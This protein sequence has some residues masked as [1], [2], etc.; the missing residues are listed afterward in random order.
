MG[1]EEGPKG[2]KFSPVSILIVRWWTQLCQ[3]RGTVF[4]QRRQ[5][6]LL[7][8]G[9]H[10]H[11]CDGEGVEKDTAGYL[12][13]ALLGASLLGYQCVRNAVVFL[14]HQLVWELLLD[15]LVTSKGQLVHRV[16]ALHRMG[17]RAR[18]RPGR[19]GRT[20]Q[21]RS[22]RLKVTTS[23]FL[24]NSLRSV[25]PPVK[26]YWTLDIQDRRKK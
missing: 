1:A 3:N 19:G 25:F 15:T 9:W 12:R 8:K 17:H 23:D 26:Q 16:S 10:P 7:R 21:S 4:L 18:Q 14:R 6:C 24:L 20:V 13:M 5:R 2:P 11:K 22:H